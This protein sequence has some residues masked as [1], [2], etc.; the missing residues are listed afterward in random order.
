MEAKSSQTRFDL[1]LVKST[2]NPPHLLRRG[3]FFIAAFNYF[4]FYSLQRSLV[5]CV[6]YHV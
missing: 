6:A 4:L 1:L 3:G 2:Y 5:K